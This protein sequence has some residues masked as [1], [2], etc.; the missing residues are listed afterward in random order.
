MVLS[1]SGIL[2]KRYALCFLEYYPYFSL[3]LHRKELYKS[4]EVSDCPLRCAKWIPSKNWIVVGADDCMIR[5][6]NVHSGDLV[7][8]W[9]AHAD[10]IRSIAVHPSKLQIVTS[11]DDFLLKVCYSLFVFFNY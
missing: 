4:I 3:F 7:K 9:E 10:Y 1:L 11:S 5:I 6:Y 2:P 8:K